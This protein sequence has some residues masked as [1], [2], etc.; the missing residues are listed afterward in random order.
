MGRGHTAFSFGIEFSAGDVWLLFT[1]EEALLSLLNLSRCRVEL[2]PVQTQEACKCCP[3][4]SL[5]FLDTAAH[6]EACSCESPG[7]LR[8]DGRH[9]GVLKEDKFLAFAWN[10]RLSVFWE[11]Q[12]GNSPRWKQELKQVFFTP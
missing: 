1:L 6:T 8:M 11:D 3:W 9:C 5:A 12:A 7:P 2:H 4:L 10:L